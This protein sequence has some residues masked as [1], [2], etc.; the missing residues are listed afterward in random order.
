MQNYAF[1]MKNRIFEVDSSLFLLE[2][3]LLVQITK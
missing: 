3:G 2:I 1:T